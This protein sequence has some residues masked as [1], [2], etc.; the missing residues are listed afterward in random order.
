MNKNA[1]EHP[2]ERPI[3]RF[4]LSFLISIP[5]SFALVF[6]IAAM[7]YSP[8]TSPLEVFP[9]DFIKVYMPPPPKPPPPPPPKPKPKPE[10][11]VVEAPKAPVAPSPE[12]ELQEEPPIVESAPELEQ[13]PSPPA[14]FE[15]TDLDEPPRAVFKVEPR[16]PELARRAGKEGRVILRILITRTGEVAR[17]LV[18]GGQ[19][20]LGFAEAAVDAVER[21]RF[22]P[23]TVGGKPVD[24]WCTL[25]IRF[26]LE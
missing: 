3:G 7:A 12:E 8:G 1:E 18:V 22:A 14:V 17:V 16:Y 10:K 20:R 4:I 15:A 25:P 19:D 5:L 9:V 6:L 23:P 2:P 13:P 26:T 11:P 21:W 24:V